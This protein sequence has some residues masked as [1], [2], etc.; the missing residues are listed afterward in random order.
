MPIHA[1]KSALRGVARSRKSLG[2][3]RRLRADQKSE[4]GDPHAYHVPIRARVE[5]NELLIRSLTVRINAKIEV[6][7]QGRHCAEFGF[8]KK[9]I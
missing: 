6:V 7:F 2:K 3:N 9:R 1:G 8:R 5:G 4:I